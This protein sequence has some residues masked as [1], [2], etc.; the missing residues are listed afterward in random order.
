MS[1]LRALPAVDPAE[2]LDTRI[3]RLRDELFSV[4][5]AARASASADSTAL[6]VSL[7]A[8]CNELGNA[9]RALRGDL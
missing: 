6:H 5:D 8:A 2:D 7:Q 3:A 1:S 9:E 4:A